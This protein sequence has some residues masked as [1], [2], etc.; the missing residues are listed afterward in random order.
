M[1]LDQL[2]LFLTV[3]LFVSASPGP[4]MLSA[5]ANGGI[6]GVR[7]AI[8]GMAGATAGN[9]LLIVLSSVGMG[10]V[11]KNS[12][13]FFS[14][15]QWVGAAYLIW[16]GI[17]ICFQSVNEN[18]DTNPKAASTHL[19]F[20][21]F[22]IAISNPKGL[23]YFGALF[24]QFIAP[25]RP[26]APQLALLVSLF[27]VMDFIWMLAYAKGGSFIMGWLRNPL[28]RRWFNG[29]AGG[30]LIFAGL[31]MVLLPAN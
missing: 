29:V 16:Q 8:W 24:P 9:L 21:S 1:H 5:M 27:V 22:G 25:E 10:L 31:I 18:I 6:Y 13:A 11:L 19:F 4:V 7:H 17:K 14:A 23:I 12:P 26:L 3:T 15:I 28:H 20:K 2:L 30:A